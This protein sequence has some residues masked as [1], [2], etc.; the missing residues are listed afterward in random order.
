[1]RPESTISLINRWLAMAV[2]LL[3]VMDAPAHGGVV[4]EEDLCV[5]EIGVFRAHFT[6]YQ[7]ATRASKEFCEDVPDVAETVFVL[8]YLHDSLREVPVDLRIIRDVMNRTLYADWDDVQGIGN[9]EAATVFYQPPVVR[10]GASFTVNY[11]FTE[12]GW[13]TGIVS[14]RHPTL[15]K[16]YHAVFGFHVGGLGWGY[17]PWL[18]L[19]VIG[20]QTHYWVSSG[21]FKRWRAGRGGSESIED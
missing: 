9:L 8:D 20:V 16:T 4:A 6:I 1:M 3:T 10:P 5:I 14:A 2:M 21:G 11:Q 7:P 12:K 15:D 18:I 17:W 19:I 13:Y